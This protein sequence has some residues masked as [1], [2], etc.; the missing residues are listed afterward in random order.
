MFTN[1][2]NEKLYAFDGIASEKTGVLHVTT[3]STGTLQWTTPSAIFDKCGES[4]GDIATNSID[5][6][7]NTYWQH[8][9]TCNHWIVFDMGA[10]KDIS[11][12]RIVQDSMSTRRW[13]GSSGIEVYVSDDPLNWG[14]AV[15]T[16]TLDSG[17]WQYSGQFSA[18]GQYIK[19]ISNDNKK[20]Q[21]LYG[22][23]FLP[24]YH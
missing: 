8:D 16:G 4:G 7:T 9:S 1:A 17:G 22:L 18:Q 23:L 11:K 21:R 3:E 10:T 24:S 15:W 20:Q 19:L 14:S 5:G 6:N 12:I 2:S 13:G